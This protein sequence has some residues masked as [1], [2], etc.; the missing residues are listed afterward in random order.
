LVLDNPVRADAMKIV[1]DD[2]SRFVSIN[3]VNAY[4]S[5]PEE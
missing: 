5:F 4:S 1:F 2:F 3:A